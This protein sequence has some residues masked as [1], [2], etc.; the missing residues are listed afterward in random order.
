MAEITDTMLSF[1]DLASLTQIFQ[2]VGATLTV[3]SDSGRCL[4][5]LLDTLAQVE[6]D[7]TETVPDLVRRCA[8]KVLQELA[9]EK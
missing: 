6:T 4:G 2:R 9:S 5:T 3:R 8:A 7:S 1:P